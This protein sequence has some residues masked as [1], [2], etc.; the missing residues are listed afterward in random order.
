MSKIITSRPIGPSLRSYA[1]AA[2]LLEC[3]LAPD[4]LLAQLKMI[5]ADD[6]G[7]RFGQRWA[8]RHMDLDIILWSGGIWASPTLSVPH[9]RFRARDFVLG[10]ATR[11]APGWRDPISSL[12]LQQLNAR[13]T[14]PRPIPR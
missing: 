5:E 2:I 7:R 3:E 13:L 9:P 14:K 11:I 8:S 6:F 1:N 4:A 12:S 10:P